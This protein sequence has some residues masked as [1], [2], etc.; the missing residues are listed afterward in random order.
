[1][2]SDLLKLSD[3]S[4]VKLSWWNFFRSNIGRGTGRGSEELRPQRAFPRT[5]ADQTSAASGLRSAN[6]I[7]A[8]YMVDSGHCSML[9]FAQLK[10]LNLI[11]DNV[12][13][14][15]VYVV[16]SIKS[17]ITIKKLGDDVLKTNMLVAI[18]A[19]LDEITK[20]VLSILV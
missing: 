6:D 13:Y 10:S 2:L 5:A 7:L 15:L 4:K 11:T 17:R 19:P 14:R 18:L 9:I 16:Q 20:M 3:L 12:C 8:N 1:M